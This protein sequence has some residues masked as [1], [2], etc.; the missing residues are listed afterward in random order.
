MHRAGVEGARRHQLGRPRLQVALGLGGELRQAPRTA[1]ILGVAGVLSDMLSSR[2][3]H[4]HAAHGIDGARFHALP[5]IPYG[6]I[7]QAWMRRIK[8]SQRARLGRIEGQVRGVARMVEEDRY[9]IDVLTQIRA[10]RAA[11][12]KVEQEILHDHLQH[13]VAHAFHAGNRARAPDQDR[14]ADGG[15]RQPAVSGA[16]GAAHIGEGKRGSHESDEAC[17]ACRDGA[18]RSG[19]TGIRP[20]LSVQ[21]DHGR[22]F[23]R[24]GWQQRPAHA[25]IGGAGIRRA[26]QARH[27]GEPLRRQRKHRPCHGRACGAGRLHARH[28]RHGSPGG[29]RRAVPNMGFDPRTSHRSFSSNV[30][31]SCS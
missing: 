23:L 4:R 13:C 17:G 21:A 3:L 24:R 5:S 31:L 7:V 2:D 19:D 29:Q 12:D 9:C 26:G 10:V 1:E 18:C 14:G 30:P 8:K 15:A 20:G 22:R 28:G 16:R 6:G 25:P 11:L 27:H